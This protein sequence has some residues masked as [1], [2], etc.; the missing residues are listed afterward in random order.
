MLIT[1]TVFPLL[2]HLSTF[3]E[4]LENIKRGMAQHP[5]LALPSNLNEDIWNYYGLH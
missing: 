1:H 4:M 3:R 2:F 5:W